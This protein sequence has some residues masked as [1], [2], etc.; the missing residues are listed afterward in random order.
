MA[1]GKSLLTELEKLFDI[2]LK[3]ENVPMEKVRGRPQKRSSGSPPKSSSL[4]MVQQSS[5]Y[6]FKNPFL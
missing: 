5:G 2:A 1:G 4:R 6:S 3:Q